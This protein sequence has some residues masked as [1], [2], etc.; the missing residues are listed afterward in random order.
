MID[1]KIEYSLKFVKSI[2]S[3]HILDVGQ[4]KL[5]KEAISYQIFADKLNILCMSSTSSGAKSSLRYSLIKLLDN[6]NYCTAGR[7]TGIGMSEEAM[8][9][10][11]GGILL[12]DEIERLPSDAL[13]PLYDILQFQTLK[14][15]KHGMHETMPVPIKILATCNP[16]GNRSE[17]IAYGN[18]GSMRD[19]LPFPIPF[20]RRFHI[21]IFLRSYTSEEFDRINRFKAKFKKENPEGVTYDKKA[22]NEFNK[23]IDDSRNMEYKKDVPDR[24]F[25]FLKNIKMFE[26]YI[27]TPITPELLEGI[28]ET[29]KARA[30]IEMSEEI[31]KSMWD[32]VMRFLIN[33]LSTGG[34][35]MRLIERRILP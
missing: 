18:T 13:T 14:I 17:W 20:L 19:Q 8:I 10:G 26:D 7:L 28:V 32:D 22:I 30:R 34:L 29:A 24:V 15:S 25:R 2:I 4:V 6:F 5:F 12:I 35:S 9:V 16:R 23:Y 1:E 33:C 11:D 21:P 27:L 3:P 31:T